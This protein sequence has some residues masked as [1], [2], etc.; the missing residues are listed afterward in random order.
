MPSNTNTL[1]AVITILGAVSLFAGLVPIIEVQIQVPYQESVPYDIE[2]E[3]INYELRQETWSYQEAPLP[4]GKIRWIGHELI[5]GDTVEF[6]IK[7]ETTGGPRPYIVDVFI[8]KRSQFT[9]YLEGNYLGS[10]NQMRDVS[11]GTLTHYIVEL[12]TYY[13]VMYNGGDFDVKITRCEIVR[14]WE[15]AVI[16]TRIEQEYRI[17]TKYQKVTKKVTIFENLIGDY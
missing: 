3:Y 5:I 10:E 7:T 2:V 6:S 14:H 1:I 8:M 15:E 13:F 16:T 12:D 4:S 9:D 11:E 17:E